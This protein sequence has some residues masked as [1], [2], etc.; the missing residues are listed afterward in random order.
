M[1]F[2]IKKK[3]EKDAKN[4]TR[5]YVDGQLSAPD[6]IPELDVPVPPP[7]ETV[8]EKPLLAEDVYAEGRSVGF[9]EGMIYAINLVQDHLH[10]HQEELKKKL[11]EVQE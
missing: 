10:K 8:K 6:K 11:Q 3:K 7:E 1:V 4:K 5:E 2:G 9:Q